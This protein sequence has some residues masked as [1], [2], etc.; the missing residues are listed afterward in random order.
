MTPGK[1]ARCAPL[2]T[3]V[4]LLVL[5]IAPATGRRR[6][7]AAVL[8]DPTLASI[9]HADIVCGHECPAQTE[10]RH[11]EEDGR[12]LG[13]LE[14]PSM[15]APSG[16]GVSAQRPT[17]VRAHSTFPSQRDTP[18]AKA[19]TR[20]GS[21]RRR[22]KNKTPT[23]LLVPS[24]HGGTKKTRRNDGKGG[25][26]FLREGAQKPSWQSW[27]LCYRLSRRK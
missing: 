10:K 23:S 4:S 25:S 19:A 3:V 2:E 14:R 20:G 27:Q 5:G 13:A 11:E 21:P 15:G 16:S 12:K 8:Q 24:P 9:E 6:H 26:F 7:L 1:G 22:Q 18:A 17:P